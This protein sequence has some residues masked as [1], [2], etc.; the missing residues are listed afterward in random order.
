M[1]DMEEEIPRDHR[2]AEMVQCLNLGNQGEKFFAEA[3][4]SY[5]VLQHLT[6]EDLQ[7]CSQ[8]LNPVNFVL[9]NILI[10]RSLGWPCQQEWLSTI[11]YGERRMEQTA[12]RELLIT[13]IA[14]HL[15]THLPHLL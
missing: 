4:I 9:F 15:K 5:E 2:I 6:K 8:L 3:K 11:T 13:K 12:V 1:S 14:L 7:V 10:S